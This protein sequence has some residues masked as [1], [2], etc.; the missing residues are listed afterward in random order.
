MVTNGSIRVNGLT[1]AYR[2]WP[3]ERGPLICLPHLTGHKGSYNWLAERLAP[4][5]R[6]LALDLRGR[7]DSDK[8]AEGYG[9]AYHARDVLAFADALGLETFTLIGHSFGATAAVYLASIRPDRVQAI[10]MLDGGADPKDSALKA[11]YPTIHR[12][13][14]AYPSLAA[15]LAAQQAAP[16]FQP[17]SAALEAY[18]IEDAETRPDG[19]VWS[20]SSAE[21]IAHD[22]DLHF[23]YCMCLHFTNL[24]SPALFVRP[25]LGLLGAKGHVFSE[26]E[27][28]A[29]VRN[30]PNCRRVDVPG[31][32]HYTML[33]HDDPPV[34]GPILEFLQDVEMKRLEIRDWPISNL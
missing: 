18:F 27:A 22:M 33:I 28:A 1:L 14:Q 34:A 5:Y 16:Y 2:E 17:W 4:E 7:G 23:L 30:I 3:G 21:A 6:V 15:Y 32:N 25:A 29:I 20:K 19:Q 10:V 8:P 11:M 24:C 12:L 13:G 31:V 9:F 26:A